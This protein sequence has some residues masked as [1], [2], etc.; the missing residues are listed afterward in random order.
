MCRL[1]VFFAEIFF[2]VLLFISADEAHS[3]SDRSRTYSTDVNR[4]AENAAS[5]ITCDFLQKG[6][7]YK[8]S[9]RLERQQLQFFRWITIWLL[10]YFTGTGT[11]VPL[12][13]R[14]PPKIWWTSVVAW[15]CLSS[16]QMGAWH[17]RFPLMRNTI[18]LL[19]E[20]EVLLRVAI[21]TRLL[22]G[23]NGVPQELVGILLA[24]KA[25]VSCNFCKGQNTFP[26][27]TGY[28]DKSTV[29]LNR[30][31]VK[32]EP[33]SACTVFS[34]TLHNSKE[35]WAHTKPT[36]R[37]VCPLL[38]NQEKMLLSVCPVLYH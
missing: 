10:R 21:Q 33:F 34:L 35:Q 12:D 36:G 17:G 3:Q 2:Y 19:P 7:K 29:I 9:K 20:T 6:L 8:W 16:L 32:K 13:L 27:E 18:Q 26:F 5:V 38:W 14:Y 28:Q 22:H 24:A 31:E 4:W 11:L 25:K 15:V 30:T 1:W 23:V 37:D